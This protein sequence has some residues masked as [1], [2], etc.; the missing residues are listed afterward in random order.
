[1]ASLSQI[2]NQYPQPSIILLE[3]PLEWWR[4]RNH[5]LGFGM[6]LRGFTMQ[7]LKYLDMLISVHNLWAPS[8]ARKT[9]GADRHPLAS[10]HF[11]HVSSKAP[12][13]SR[14]GPAILQLAQTGTRSRPRQ[15]NTIHHHGI[16]GIWPFHPLIWPFHPLNLWS[17]SPLFSLFRS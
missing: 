14:W 1:M 16:C 10:L 2:T 8:S 17:F 3:V 6:F 9:W 5:H 15:K 13:L 4:L 7:L 11:S 12:K